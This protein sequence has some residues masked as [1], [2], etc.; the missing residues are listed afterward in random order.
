[1][2]KSACLRQGGPGRLLARLLARL[3]QLQF[4]A[5][6]AQNK[7]VPRA[8]RAEWLSKNRCVV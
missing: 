6:L 7:F 8:L 2:R 1:M 4:M 5:K 3:P